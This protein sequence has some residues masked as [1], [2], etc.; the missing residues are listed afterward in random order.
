MTYVIG[1]PLLAL[2]S[3]LQATVLARF[4]V[5][6]GTIDLV[7]LLTL[8]W[9]LIG[10]WQGGIIWGLL[11]GLL[12]DLLSGAPLGSAPLGLILAA[13]L[14]GLTEGRLW[15]SHVLVP[16]ATALA[17]TLVYHLV[18]LAALSLSGYGLSWGVGLARITLPA[19]FLNTLCMLPVYHVVRLLHSFAHPAPVTI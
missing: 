8:S 16:L 19:L 2:A 9:T 14:A 7:L 5:F 17:G 18:S 12:L 13:Y 15:R 3:V 4:H 10:E 1:L 11:G 6:G